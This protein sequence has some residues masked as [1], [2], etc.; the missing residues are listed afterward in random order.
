MTTNLTHWVADLARTHATSL[1]H[2][3]V[4][5]GLSSDDAIDAVQDAFHALLALPQGRAVARSTADAAALM[6]V[7][8][9]NTAR[10]LRRRHHR[11]IAH[12]ALDAEAL[13]A[14][15]LS[16]SELLERVEE[17]V[18]LL[19]CVNQLASLQRQVVTLRMLE[20]FSAPEVACSLGLSTGHVA[21]LLH[22]ANRRLLEC[23]MGS[24]AA[25]R[26]M[27]QPG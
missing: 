5:E 4:R 12:E 3:A 10:N 6:T 1:A 17:H 24:E 27:P 8:V 16:V 14:P 21:V 25:S 23:L 18:A 9:R 19:G 22:R 20:E 7:V 13:P 26:S 2:V 11:A 15:T